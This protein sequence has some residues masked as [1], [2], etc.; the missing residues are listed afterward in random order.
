MSTLEKKKDYAER[1]ARAY[2]EFKKRTDNNQILTQQEKAERRELFLESHISIFDDYYAEL[3]ARPR[4]LGRINLNSNERLSDE[5]RDMAA[6][7]AA[8]YAS[9]RTGLF[10]MNAVAANQTDRQ[11]R[12]LDQRAFDL[13][14]RQNA[15]DSATSHTAAINSTYKTKIKRASMDFGDYNAGSAVSVISPQAESVHRVAQARAAADQARTRAENTRTQ[16]DKAQRDADDAVVNDPYNASNPEAIQAAETAWRTAS[17]AQTAS[18]VAR[19]DADRIQLEE[20]GNLAT[21][22]T[23]SIQVRDDGLTSAQIKGIREVSAFL[24]RNTLHGSD[25]KTEDRGYLMDSILKAPPR[26]KLLIYYLVQNDMMHGQLTGPQIV[27][28]LMFTP[29]LDEFKSHI[30]GAFKGIFGRSSGNS[31]KWSKLSGAVHGAE[32][33]MPKVDKMLGLDAAAPGGAGGAGAGGAP[34][35]GAGLDPGLA[36]AIQNVV[37]AGRIIT[38]NP[39]PTQEQIGKFVNAVQDLNALVSAQEGNAWDNFQNW[40]TDKNQY[41]G[42]LAKPLSAIAGVLGG[43]SKVQME[44]MDKSLSGNPIILPKK[45]HDA[46]VEAAGHDMGVAKT[47]V[48]WGSVPLGTLTAL[49]SCITLLGS[50]VSIFRQT[51]AA[52]TGMQFLRF[53]NN[54]ASTANGVYSSVKGIAGMAG[55]SWVTSAAAVNAAGGAGI[56]VGAFSFVQGAYRTASANNER[57]RIDAFRAGLSQQ[58]QGVLEEKRQL[59][60]EITAAERDST[61][62]RATAGGFQ[63][64][65]AGLQVFA[66]AAMLFSGGTA[67]IIS[68]AA[69]GTAFLLSLTGAIVSAVQKNGEK[70]AV[71]DRYIDLDG[72]YRRFM[73]DHGGP[74]ANF[75]K[76]YGNEKKCKE[77]LRKFALRSLSFTSVDE[78]YTHIIRKYAEALYKGTFLANDGSIMTQAAL[79]AEAQNNPGEHQQR[80]LFAECLK[81]FGLTV[82]Y[83]NADGDRPRVKEPYPGVGVIYKKLMK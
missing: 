54:T 26:E 36:Q 32:D 39:N 3:D 6:D 55:A 1:A 45:E 40:L 82:K 51:S 14:T 71:V 57:K 37:Q 34:G 18:A 27:Q 11:A 80:Q 8:L 43:I 44:A 60:L 10:F 25:K 50:F 4:Q 58:Q 21:R 48:S 31:I 9:S 66:G 42:Y 28:A 7:I 77:N 33:L 5:A 15:R 74:G 13:H 78:M 68:A 22:R 17:Q 69:S 23:F 38:G 16:A 64:A 53:A 81:A 20:E 47:Y 29:V 56:V 35:G 61:K 72:F 79:Q 65:A 73:A 19:A 83:P 30:L 59:L 63:M 67:A 2:A 62:R 46:I 12:A 24:Y 75:E 70:K 76:R 49:I 52:D 41:V